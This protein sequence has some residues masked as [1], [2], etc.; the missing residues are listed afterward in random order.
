MPGGK[1]DIDNPHGWVSQHVVLKSLALDAE[2][3]DR[4][5][6]PQE[7]AH[8]SSGSCSFG[9]CTRADC[10]RGRWRMQLDRM[11]S[12]AKI[13]PK[14]HPTLNCRPGLVGTPSARAECRANYTAT[15][16]SSTAQ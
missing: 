10:G 8:A 14:S 9:W 11:E 3:A 16:L 13:G 1:I 15:Q 5:H 6:R 12:P 2:P 7:L 4:T